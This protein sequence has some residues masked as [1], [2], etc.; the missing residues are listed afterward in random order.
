MVTV[1]MDISILDY[2]CKHVSLDIQDNKGRFEVDIM[3][4]DLK[5]VSL[6]W[7]TLHIGFKVLPFDNEYTEIIIS[8]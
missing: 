7:L 8:F 3:G 1:T 4:G 2:E 6:V 5:K